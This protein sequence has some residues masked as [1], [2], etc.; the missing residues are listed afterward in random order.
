MAYPKK[1]LVKVKLEVL[2]EADDDEEYEEK[3]KDLISDIKNV[4]HVGQVDLLDEE[5][6]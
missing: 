4:G 3:K 6:V 2:L 5:D 1:K